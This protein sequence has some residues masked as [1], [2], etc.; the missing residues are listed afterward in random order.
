MLSLNKNFHLY[1]LPLYYT[2]HEQYKAFSNLGVKS[3][4]I[5]TMTKPEKLPTFTGLVL[6]ALFDL[7]TLTIAFSVNIFHV[8]T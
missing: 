8:I 2:T 1:I 7:L 4:K 5:G 3:R 6:Y